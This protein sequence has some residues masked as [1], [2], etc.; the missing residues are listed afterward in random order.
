[1]RI[2]IF[3]RR[4]QKNY[5]QDLGKFCAE[6][7]QILRRKFLRYGKTCFF[8]RSCPKYSFRGTSRTPP[9]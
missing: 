8:C 2:K 3:M 4:I 1:M 9:P 5:A 7:E 6:S